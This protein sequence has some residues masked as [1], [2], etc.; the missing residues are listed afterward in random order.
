MQSQI[1]QGLR[2][3]KNNVLNFLKTKST[4]FS[5]RVGGLKL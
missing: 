3:F 2:T 5:G 1:Q 4:S